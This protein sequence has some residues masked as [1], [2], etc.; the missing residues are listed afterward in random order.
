MSAD[1]NVL[2]ERVRKLTPEQMDTLERVLDAIETTPTTKM[3]QQIDRPLSEYEFFGMWAD[4]EEMK[5]SVAWVRKLR[6]TE[7]R[8]DHNPSE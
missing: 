3:P 4:R 5:D 2:I 6:E 8:R 7:W 1:A